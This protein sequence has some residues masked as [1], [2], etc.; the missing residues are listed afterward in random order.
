LSG[1]PKAKEIVLSDPAIEKAAKS[2]AGLYGSNF[3][4]KTSGRY[5]IPQ[6]LMRD[7][8]GRRRIYPKQVQ[9]LTRAMLELGF[10]LIDMDSFFVVLG[11]N[12]FV[13]YR[14]VN[15]DGL[16]HKNGSQSG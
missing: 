13:N 11:S 2:L 4:G 8:L 10:V 12:A 15:Q 7:L 5:R 6:K 3:G 9:Q 1:N 14:R 16:P